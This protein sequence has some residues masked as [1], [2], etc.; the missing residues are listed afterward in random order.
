MITKPE[1]KPIELKFK[2]KFSTQ[3]WLFFLPK[4][5]KIMLARQQI[6]TSIICK[7]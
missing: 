7:Y 6:I 2:F 5:K 4:G 1:I 3:V